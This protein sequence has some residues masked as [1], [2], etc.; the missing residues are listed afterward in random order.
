MV[1]VEHL[2]GYPI[3]KAT[4]RGTAEVV[5]SFMETNIIL[6]FGAP[7]I[8]VSVNTIC[9]SARD[10]QDFMQLQNTKGH[11]LLVYVPLSNDRAKRM[12]GKM[13]QGI[14]RLLNDCGADWD[15]LVE[16][17][18]FGYCWRPQRGGKSPF[19]LLGGEKPKKIHFVDKD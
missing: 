7:G 12:I 17:L 4:G 10:P 15:T 2:T 8:V 14:G 9:F 18:V 1:C 13:K 11:T 19:D 3:V 6:P 5:Q 16:R